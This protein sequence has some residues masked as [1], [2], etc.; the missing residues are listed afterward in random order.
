[1]SAEVSF[2]VPLSAFA[3]WDVAHGRWRLEPGPYALLVG[4]SS[5]DVR[6]R[7]T[8]TLDGEPAAP[9]PVLERG[10]AA[11]DFDEQSGTEIVDRTK[12]SGDAVT[13][14]SDTSGELLYRACDFGPG[15]TSVTVEVSGGG[16]VE[17][18][19]DGGPVR[20]VLSTDTPT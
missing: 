15:V 13:P 19:L 20:A 8:L 10:L 1:A 7:T 5:E 12:E 16:V 2:D 18:S 17:L 3:F 6:L 11:A 4:A 14:A 9:R